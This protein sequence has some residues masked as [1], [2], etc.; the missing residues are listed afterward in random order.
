MTPEGAQLMY[1]LFFFFSAYWGGAL[2]EVQVAK[3][4]IIFFD[5]DTRER[6]NLYMI[7]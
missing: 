6:G 7:S 2:S 3:L 1:P 5:E 4:A